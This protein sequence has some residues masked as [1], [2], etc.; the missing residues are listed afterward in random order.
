MSSGSVRLEAL[1]AEREACSGHGARPPPSSL[2][3]YRLSP[4]SSGLCF[5]SL[6]GAVEEGAPCLPWVGPCPLATCGQGSA[7][8]PPCLSP[9]QNK[10]QRLLGAG[11]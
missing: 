6:G 8:R 4:S 7:R 3:G 5:P 1:R 9:E 10:A 11:S 2:P